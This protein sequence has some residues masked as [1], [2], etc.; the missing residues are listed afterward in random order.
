MTLSRHIV[1]R[2]SNF[3]KPKQSSLLACCL[4][5]KLWMGVCAICDNGDL[6]LHTSAISTDIQEYFLFQ[7]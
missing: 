7:L 2:R 4:H 1:I 5:N 3:L 6:S